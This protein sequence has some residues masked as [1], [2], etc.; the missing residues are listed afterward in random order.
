MSDPITVIEQQTAVALERIAGATTTAELREAEIAAL[1]RKAP[2]SQVKASLAQATPEQRKEIGRA[3]NEARAAIESALAEREGTFRAAEEAA[4]LQ[5]D[6]IDVTLPGRRTPPGRPHPI[7]M[8]TEWLVDIFVGMGFNVAEG[9]EIETD[10]YNFEALN[11]HEDHPARTMQDTMFVQ[12]AQSTLVARTHTSP[13]QIR[14]MLASE[15]PLYV[16][17]P[18]RTYRR[19]PFDATHSPVFHQIEGLAVD[20]DISLA[21]LKGVLTEFARAVFGPKQKVRLRPSYFPFTE[22]SAEVDVVCPRCGGNGCG[23]CSRSG[24]MEIMGAG[25]VHPNVLR[26]GEYDPAAWSGFAF[27]MGI[28]RIAMTAWPVGDIR[29]LF[30]NDLRFLGRFAG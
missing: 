10:W 9:P 17:A 14:S 22:P 18:G 2:M 20:R 23:P 8:M 24:W 6:R 1:G 7:S 27:G 30:E 5:R 29:N 15:G 3:L 13:V 11:M 26:A 12:G 21:D 19:D 28:E 4:A 16:V 25:M